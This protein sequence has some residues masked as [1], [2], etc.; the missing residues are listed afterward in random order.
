MTIDRPPRVEL[1]PGLLVPRLLTGLW[2][3]ADMERDR[4]PLDRA[5]AATALAEY[6]R[7]GFDAFDMADHY[8]SAEDIAGHL[9]AGG[10]SAVAFTKW[11]PPP[12][13]MTPDI[14]AEGVGRSFAR[15]GIPR[16]D[17]MQFHW[18]Q[19]RHPAYLDALVEMARLR[20]EGKFR[21]I[22]LTNFDTDHLRLLL[23]HGI[24]IATNQVSFS[25]LDRRA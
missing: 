3:V 5:A 22:G 19:Y 14:V 21:A 6:V 11:C 18:W 10:A 23:K 16:I 4:P 17:L 24:P 1:V 8:G 12:G 20:A 25:L 13:P 9:L 2:Q 7:A 15:L